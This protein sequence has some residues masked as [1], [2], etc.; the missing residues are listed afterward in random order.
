MTVALYSKKSPKLTGNHSATSGG[1]SFKSIVALLGYS[2]VTILQELSR[3]ANKTAEEKR[4]SAGGG[5]HNPPLAQE[6]WSQDDCGNNEGRRRAFV[7]TFI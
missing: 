7:S 6:V 5:P 3:N 2:L 1:K 4:D